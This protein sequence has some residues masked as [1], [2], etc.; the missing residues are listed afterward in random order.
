M[1]GTGLRPARLSADKENLACMGRKLAFNTA[2]GNL[3]AHAV[4]L[5]L[6]C[7]SSL[8]PRPFWPREEGSGVHTM[9]FYSVPSVVL[10]LLM[11]QLDYAHS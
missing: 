10:T 1:A 3:L 9:P 4:F 2:S 6:P 8:D 11:I 5:A 7:H